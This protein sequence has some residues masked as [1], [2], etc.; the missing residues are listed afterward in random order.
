[1][2]LLSTSG[3]SN[4]IEN[5]RY[6]EQN[7]RI[8][9]LEVKKSKYSRM[10]GAWGDLKSK[11]DGFKSA[12]YGLKLSTSSSIFNARSTQ[13]SS[14]E[15]LDVSASSN[16]SVSAYLLRVNQLAKN[17]LVVSQTKASDTSSGISA[18]TNR[19]QIIS[20]DYTS[21][22]D[23]VTTG[24]ETYEELMDAMS[25]AIN[26]DKAIVNSASLNASSSYTGSGEFTIDLDGT[27]TAIE[28]DYS[29]GNTYEEVIDDL[30][31][32]I[33]DGVSG[34]LAQK[35]VDG[36][37][38]SLKITAS[39]SEDYITIDSATDTGTL[40][41]GSN[42]NVN[43]EKEKGASGLVTS[44]FFSPSSANSKFSL[45]AKESGY[46]NRLIMSDTSG[47]ALD[48]I[49]LTSAI[50]SSRTNITGDDDAGYVYSVTDSTD[51]ELNAK[52][53][54]NGINIQRNEN[55]ISDL[56]ENV[57]FTLKAQMDAED[58]TVNV[59][60]DIDTE[61]IKSKVNEFINKFNETY[62]Y[63]KN[64]Y[65][66]DSLGRGLFVGNST[67]SSLLRTLSSSVMSAVSGLPQDDMSYL[68]QIGIRFDPVTGLKMTDESLFVTS[69]KDNPSEVGALF[70]SENGI[71]ATLYSNMESY[72]G[73][74]GIISNITKSYDKSVSYLNDKID[75]TNTSIEKRA[76]ILRSQYEQLQMQM[77]A[78]YQNQSFFSS[79]NG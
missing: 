77:M 60:V 40:L 57:T 53:N 73:S 76:T 11:L 3:I 5:F 26:S 78:L 68:S 51:N 12:L 59:S 72:L 30:I 54:F 15:F 37:N 18:G 13:T 58:Q 4:L 66:S 1:M 33:N 61:N 56:V 16:A 14:K 38:V 17:D 2:D 74:S 65:A 55:T 24:T 45:T 79:L 62:S 10:S 70:N 67:A 28:Y 75:S 46:D 20:G 23:L 36:S 19:F 31:L 71:A 64:N 63:I 21:N 39:D 50:L 29:A 22:V 69:L 44:S 6:V 47:S 34:V 48:A 8:S 27:E 35:V 52:F 43:V 7:K 49:G 32:K 42:L 9:P 25:S 41:N